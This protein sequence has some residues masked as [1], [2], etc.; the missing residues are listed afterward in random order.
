MILFIGSLYPLL[1][2]NHFIKLTFNFYTLLSVK[3]LQIVSAPYPYGTYVF[4]SPKSLLKVMV[5]VPILVLEAFV[6]NTFIAVK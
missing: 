4:A 2:T 6:I 1:N 3:L 5:S